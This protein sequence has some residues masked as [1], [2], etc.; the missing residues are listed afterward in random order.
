MINFVLDTDVIIA[1]MRSPTG[2]SAALIGSALKK[3]MI[4]LANVPLFLEYE[5]KCTSAQHWTEAG[6]THQQAQIFVDA[7]AVLVK[8][9]KTYYLWRPMLRDPNDEMVLEAA[10]NGGADAIVTFNVKDFGNIPNRL[11]IEVIQPS[12]AIRR[13]RNG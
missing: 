1:A 2:A 5:A 8:P 10:V 4:M 11:N 3:E 13:V 12:T 6:L 9:V 7:L